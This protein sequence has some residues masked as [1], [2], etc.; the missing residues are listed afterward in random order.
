VGSAGPCDEVDPH[1]VAELLDLAAPLPGALVVAHAL[2]RIEQQATG[3]PRGHDL[4]VLT[5][6]RR[7]RGLV[8]AAHSGLGLTFGHERDALAGQREHLQ[9]DHAEP[10]AEFP[11]PDAELSRPRLIALRHGHVAEQRVEPTVLRTELGPLEDSGRAPEP[12][13]GDRAFAP[14]HHVIVGEPDRQHPGPPHLS[15]PAAKPVGALARREAGGHV[16]D[17]PRSPAQPLQRLDRLA[18]LELPLENRPRL[19]PVPSRE[20]R[21]AIP[22]PAARRRDLSHVRTH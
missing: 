11:R 18:K 1:P 4:L 7:R 5:R 8:E 12:A 19:F 6:Q 20:R 13:A 14:K 22:N 10:A 15:L 16:L 2:A 3:P 17:P 9:R 21:F